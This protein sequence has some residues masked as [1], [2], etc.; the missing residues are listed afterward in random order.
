MPKPIICLSTALRQFAEA[1]RP[2]FSKR[3]WK[4]FVTVL[5][6]L[7]ECEQRRTLCGL[8]AS[9]GEKVSLCG[10]SR[11]F[12]RWRWSVAEVAQT[13]LQRFRERMK[14][15]VEAEHQRQKAGREKCCGRPPA[16]VVTGY[17]MLD[18]PVHTKAKGRKME[19][20][21]W[22]YSRT[23]KRVVPGHCL[24]IGLYVLLGCRSPLQPRL[25]R[26]KAVCQQEGFAFQSKIDLAVEEIKQFEPVAGIATHLLIDSWYQCKPVRQAAQKRGWDVSGGLK[27]NRKLRLVAEDGHR[28]WVALSD[29]AAQL[30]PEDWQE[31][32]WPS[33]EGG[34]PVYAHA[35]Q[36]WIRK[37]GP[38]LVL[39]T[40]HDPLQPGQSI[41]YWGSTLLE[42]DAQTVI[43]ILA[44]RWSIEVLFE[45]GKDLLGT[46][47]YQLM[48]AEAI[49]RFWTLIACL[50]CFLDEQRVT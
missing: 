26:Q 4:Y 33:Q 9:V 44:M 23:E 10:L 13:W 28:S 20:L 16:T 5:L 30:Q 12:N 35:V 17:L 36:T 43:N 1:F 49:L 32:V 31:A 47:H 22:H 21:G 38:T 41:R 8:L 19:G 45:D 6:G 48:S 2:C 14:P 39:I 29:Y 46:D 34:Q 27:S 37:L 40:C 24:F 25:Y 18:D 3:Q 50:S 7:V 11:F 42:A 15:L